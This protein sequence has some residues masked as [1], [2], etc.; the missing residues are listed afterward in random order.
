MYYELLAHGYPHEVAQ[1]GSLSFLNNNRKKNN[2]RLGPRITVFDIAVRVKR[3]YDVVAEHRLVIIINF[4]ENIMGLH[5]DEQVR[6]I[7]GRPC[8]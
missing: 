4:F 6:V 5:C 8:F 1:C 3:F 7:K 2:F